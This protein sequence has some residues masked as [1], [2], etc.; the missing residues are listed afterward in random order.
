MMLRDDYERLQKVAPKEL[1]PYLSLNNHRYLQIKDDRTF[2]TKKEKLHKNKKY[3][4][5]I[6]IFP[7]D[8]TITE[9]KQLKRVLY[10]VGEDNITIRHWPKRG[11]DRDLFFKKFHKKCKVW[12]DVETSCIC[13]FTVGYHTGCIKYKKDFKE[14]VFLK[15]EGFDMPV[16]K[17]YQKIL[18]DLYGDWETPQ[19]NQTNLLFYAN[20]DM[21]FE[22]M[23]KNN[24]DWKTQ[25]FIEI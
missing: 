22:T 12:H 4:I 24:I 2:L 16:P 23:L 5:F 17:N 20:T 13:N 6:D 21:N 18:S 11:M 15:F 9:E 19:M 10:E 1:P 25:K 3:G 8:N 14:T 7:F